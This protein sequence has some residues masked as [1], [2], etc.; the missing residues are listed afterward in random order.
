[1]F[2][3]GLHLKISVVHLKKIPYIKIG[4]P[5]ELCAYLFLFFPWRGCLF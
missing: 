4:N 5:E 2:E 3:N 1:M